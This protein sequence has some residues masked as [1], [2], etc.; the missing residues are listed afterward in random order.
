LLQQG[1]SLLLHARLERQ[2]LLGDLRQH[3]VDGLLSQAEI[4]FGLK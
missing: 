3:G 4:L 1:P 2:L